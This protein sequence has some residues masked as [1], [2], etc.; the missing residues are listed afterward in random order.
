VVVV[1]VTNFCITVIIPEKESKEAEDSEES[2][3]FKISA[4]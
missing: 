1:V 3:D 4:S 2:E